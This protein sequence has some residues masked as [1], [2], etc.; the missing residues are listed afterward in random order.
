MTLVL[1]L[2]VLVGTVEQFP[3]W[4][5]APAEAAPPLRLRPGGVA[6]A[7]GSKHPVQMSEMTLKLLEGSVHIYPPFGGGTREIFEKS[8]PPNIDFPLGNR[9]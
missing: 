9:I 3:L 4:A 8:D 1:L 2:G 5:Q 6:G 7:P